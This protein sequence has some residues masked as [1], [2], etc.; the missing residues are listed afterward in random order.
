MA[1]RKVDMPD[2]F[3]ALE[4]TIGAETGQ[5]ALAWQIESVT[6]CGVRGNRTY[7][8]LANQ[9]V[10]P[11]VAGKPFL[12]VK[13]T[14]KIPAPVLV[15]SQNPTAMSRHTAVTV[16]GSAAATVDAGVTAIGALIAADLAA[17]NIPAETQTVEGALLATNT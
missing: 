1:Y 14:L 10:N 16:P 8:I 9:L 15:T 2:V 5:N 12:P 17:G 7:Y 4:E 11:T 6:G 13:V 3:M